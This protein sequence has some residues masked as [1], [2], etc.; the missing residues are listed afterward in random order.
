MSAVSPITSMIDT[1][2]RLC[3]MKRSSSTAPFVETPER[4]AEPV[5]EVEEEVE[6]C[7]CSIAGEGRG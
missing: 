2:I 1:T 3:G 7:D 6:V 4:V 5:R